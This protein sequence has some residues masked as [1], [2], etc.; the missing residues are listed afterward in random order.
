M[1]LLLLLILWDAE[2]LDFDVAIG[3]IALY[4][5]ELEAADHLQRQSIRSFLKGK[6]RR[7]LRDSRTD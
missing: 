6:G 3:V 7:I 5:R 4:I 1:S 2:D